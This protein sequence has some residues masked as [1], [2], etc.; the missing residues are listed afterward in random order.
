MKTTLFLDLGGPCHPAQSVVL[1]RDG[2]MYGD[3]AFCWLEPLLQ[4][5]DEWPGVDVVVHSTW[6]FIDETDAE[7]KAR[8]PE[9]LA[10]RVLCATP[11]DIT[12]RHESIQAYC[13]QHAIEQF[14]I[15]DDELLAFP[16]GLPQLIDCSR[17]GL[18][19]PE[20]VQAL[21]DALRRF[22]QV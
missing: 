2:K 3:D 7:L 20:T 22:R 6:R 8:L 17:G 10:R 16:P 18:S 4:I 21:R 11:R 1:G 9:A 13:E 14:V 12:G 19:N 15:L 5:L